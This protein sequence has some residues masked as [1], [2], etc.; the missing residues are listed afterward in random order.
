MDELYL[1]ILWLLVA[2]VLPI[3]KRC[4]RTCSNNASIGSLLEANPISARYIRTIIALGLSV[5]VTVMFLAVL[6][7]AF[8]VSPVMFVICLL[9]GIATGSTIAGQEFLPFSPIALAIIWFVFSVVSLVLL[10]LSLIH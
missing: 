8:S 7:A 5:V 10:L 6:I 9:M 3:L 2:W 1:W 4:H